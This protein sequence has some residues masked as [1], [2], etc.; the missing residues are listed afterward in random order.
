MTNQKQV[1]HPAASQQTGS[2]EIPDRACGSGP[3]AQACMPFDY[4]DEVLEETMVASDPPALTPQTA[5]GSPDR[6][7]DAEGH[8]ARR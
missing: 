7:A 6:D 4:I 8:R 1:H 5:I 3:D 2:E